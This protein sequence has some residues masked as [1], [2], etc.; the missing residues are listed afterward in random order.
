[1]EWEDPWHAGSPHAPRSGGHDS[2]GRWPPWRWSS[3]SHRSRPRSPGPRRCRVTTSPG[4]SVRSPSA[5]T[6]CRC[7][8]RRPA[9]SS[10]G[11]PRVCRSRG[12]RVWPT[13]STWV[14]S[15][16]KPAQAYTMAA[17][18]TAAQLATYRAKGPWSSTHPGRPAVQRRLRRGDVRRRGAEA[19]RLRAA[20]GLGRRRTAARPAL[21]DGHRL[22]ATREPVRRRG[23]D[24]RPARREVLLRR[25]LLPVRVA[26]HHRL[27]V[28]AR[29][30]GL[31][32]RGP[33]GLPGRGAGPVPPGRASPAGA[34]RWRSGTTTPGT[35]T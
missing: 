33:P 19:G 31:G 10:S 2:S 3:A 14:K 26:V 20:R 6:G 29:G 7:R 9:S 4:R 11:S 24:A 8:R 23:T 18:P 30:A 12:T 13:R 34:S 15:H 27:L 28:A 35:T 1:M 17:F 32:H 5:G 16:G 21:A 22:A 25:L